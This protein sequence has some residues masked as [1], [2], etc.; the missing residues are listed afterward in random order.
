MAERQGAKTRVAA[1]RADSRADTIVLGNVFC[2]TGGVVVA[3]VGARA[4]E[5]GQVELVDLVSSD[6]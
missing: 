2:G 1:A 3:P 6:D 5:D 4:G